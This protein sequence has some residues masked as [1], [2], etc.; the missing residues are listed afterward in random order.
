MARGG[1]TVETEVVV[2]P[3]EVY[4]HLL[5]PENQLGLQPLL[6]GI[7]AIERDRDE[8]GRQRSRFETVERFR[9][10]GALSYDNRIRVECIGLE[11]DR[12]VGFTAW[13][14]PGIVV[15]S[16]FLL[17]TIGGGR[18]TRVVESLEIEAPRL[19]LG[20][21]L[22]IARRAHAQLVENLRI[23]MADRAPR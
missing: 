2:E 23:R 3:A 1:F 16:E 4:A 15:H 14:R 11:L 22:R 17:E 13:S 6:T 12:R 9:L 8:A 19:L 20:I 10:A 7:E 18:A 21:T 5:E